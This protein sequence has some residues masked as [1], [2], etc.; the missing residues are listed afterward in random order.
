MLT[1]TTALKDPALY[2]QMQMP[3]LDPD[4]RL[5][6]E[7]LQAEIDYYRARGYYTGTATL[8]TVVDSSFAEYAAQ[9]LGPYR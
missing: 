2:E 1:E 7:S 6:R 8:D 9:Q 3:G 4:G 5:R